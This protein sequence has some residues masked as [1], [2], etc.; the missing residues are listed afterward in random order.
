[1]ASTETDDASREVKVS[2]KIKA[3]AIILF[4]VIRPD[5]ILLL[6]RDTVWNDLLF[7][8]ADCLA[9]SFYSQDLSGKNNT[10]Q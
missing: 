6:S 2:G 4:L 3:R 1:M 9:R 5:A 10:F 7:T 8:E